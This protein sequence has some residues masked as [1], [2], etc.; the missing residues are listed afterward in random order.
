MKK[1][2]SKYDDMVTA[3]LTKCIKKYAANGRFDL[4]SQ[5]LLCLSIHLKCR[6]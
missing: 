2:Q 1:E 3:H 6:T 4:L 5:T